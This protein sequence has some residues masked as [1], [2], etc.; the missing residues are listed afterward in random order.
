MDEDVEEDDGDD[1]VVV[2]EEDCGTKASVWSLSSEVSE[3]LLLKDE[4]E[5]EDEEDEAVAELL[6]CSVQMA[7]TGC[8]GLGGGV[9]SGGSAGAMLSVLLLELLSGVSVADAV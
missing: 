6:L 8:G 2:E 9:R 5:D 3:T 4:T 1:V 7:G